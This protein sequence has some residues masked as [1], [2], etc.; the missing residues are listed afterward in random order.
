MLNLFVSVKIK[1]TVVLSN[2]Y[3]QIISY[4]ESLQYN[5]RCR[6]KCEVGPQLWRTDL[7]CP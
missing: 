6:C 3:C 5:S 4:N 2:L 1:E 7:S